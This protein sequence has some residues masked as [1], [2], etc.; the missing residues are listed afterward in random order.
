ME[1]VSS[2]REEN[3]HEQGGIFMNHIK[4]TFWPLH[5]KLTQSNYLLDI[6]FFADVFKIYTFQ[7]KKLL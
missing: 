2:V 1:S 6:F 7:G 3:V 5:L 4:P